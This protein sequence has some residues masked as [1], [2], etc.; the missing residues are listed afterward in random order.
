M[1]HPT[2]T[3]K[4]ARVASADTEAAFHKFNTPLDSQSGGP[5]PPLAVMPSPLVAG[6]AVS[7]PRGAGS[8]PGAPAA[9]PC[10]RP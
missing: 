4:H 6:A 10:P 8:G 7:A 5:T 1:H 9:R 2:T 3:G